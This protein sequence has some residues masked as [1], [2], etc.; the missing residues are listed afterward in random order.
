MRRGLIH[1]CAILADKSVKCWG[2]NSYGR[3][4]GG[5]PL[6]QGEEATHLSTGDYHTCAI[7]ADKS[8]KCWGSNTSGQIGG[9]GPSSSSKTTSGTSG[10]PLTQGEEATHISAGWRHTCAILANK[11]VKCWGSSSSGQTGGGTSNPSKTTS[12]TPGSPLTQGEEATHLSAGDYHT[13]AILANKSVK[14]WGLNTRGQTGGGN[15]LNS[16]GR[17]YAHFGGGLSHLCHFSQ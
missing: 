12:G 4:G 16:G 3:T 17:G 7:L 5:S 15:P 14:C 10:S 6:T 9:G 2:S 1:T 11:S 8:V 13:C